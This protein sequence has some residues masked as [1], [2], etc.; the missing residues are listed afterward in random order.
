MSFS[1]YLAKPI[2][3]TANA[4]DD[5]VATASEARQLRGLLGELQWT[6]TQACPHLSRS[7]SVLQGQ[8][9]SVQVKHLKE[10]NKVLRF[11]KANRR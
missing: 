2:V 6:S 9:P 7:V 8:I 11:A 10:A 1:E 4:A 5:R 3:V